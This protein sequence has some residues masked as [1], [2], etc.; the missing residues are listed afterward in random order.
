MFNKES[1]RLTTI[2]CLIVIAC[3]AQTAD[4]Q[5]SDIRENFRLINDDRNLIIGDTI[6]LV[7][8]SSESGF[9][10]KITDLK[11]NLKKIVVNYYG[12]TGQSIEEYY[13]TDGRL[14]FCFTK[15]INY[16]RPIYYN[17][18]IAADNGENEAFD[19]KKSKIEE[20]RYFY[21][22]DQKLI[23]MIDK[24]R[25]VIRD[26]KILVESEAEIMQEYSRLKEKKK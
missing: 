20:T 16:N 22:T 4:K 12:E 15:Q 6:N 10:I 18:K 26:K 24:N 3:Q 8:E 5:I 25:A 9:M 21:S 2:L 14:F 23:Q 7:G 19:I 11:G 17:K 13:V 1:I